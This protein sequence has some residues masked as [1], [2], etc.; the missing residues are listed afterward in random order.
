MGIAEALN[1]IEARLSPSRER[2]DALQSLVGQSPS[3]LEIKESIRQIAPTELTVLITGE[4]GTGKDIIARTIHQLS[5][6]GEKAFVKINCAALPE[7]LLEAELFG[8]EKGAFT[9][10][11]DAKPG[12]FEFARS[13]TILLDEIGEMSSLLQAK[14]LQVIEEKRFMRLGGRK[15]IEVDVRLIAATN[16]DVEKSLAEGILRY[17]LFYRL[18]EAIISVS[19]L[20][21]RKED[22][23]LLVHH[24]LEKYS[25]Y[26]QVECPSL[27]SPTLRMVSEY[28]WPGNVRELENA[29]KRMVVFNGEKV[30]AA[31][32]KNRRRK[33][34]PTEEETTDKETQ[35]EEEPFSL[36]EISKEASL[37]AEREAI[38]TALTK[39]RWNR[40]KAA[41]E[42]RVSYKTLLSRIKECDF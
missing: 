24:F 23:P 41:K 10:A 21:E 4:S 14:L 16:R 32:T 40:V 31:V 6:R 8:Y 36:K 39:A 12:R 28:D 13:G 15:D 37:K 27:S 5:S 33:K 20:R 9:G 25:H 30:L 29:V 18:T 3:I 17:D 7:T 34:G 35:K 2:R 22:I 38:L 1:F 11:H 42:L 19:P 26:Y